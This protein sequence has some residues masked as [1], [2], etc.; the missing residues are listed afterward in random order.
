TGAQTQAVKLGTTVGNI[1]LEGFSYDPLTTD[2]T[3]LGF[4]GVKESGPLGLFQ[5]T[6]DFATG[7]ASNASP[8]TDNPAN[9]FDPALVGTSDLSDVFPLSQ[10]PDFEEGESPNLVIISQESG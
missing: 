3:G 10:L 6:V 7:T 2:G 8:S 5:T 1:G 4:I 9:L